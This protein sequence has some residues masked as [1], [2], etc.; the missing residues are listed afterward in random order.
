MEKLPISAGSLVNPG[1][2]ASCIPFTNLPNGM[3]KMKSFLVLKKR[4]ALYLTLLALLAISGCNESEIWCP[5]ELTAC[6]GTCYSLKT[7]NTHCGECGNACTGGKICSGGKCLVNCP[8]GQQLCTAGTQEYCAEVDKDINN[9]GSCGQK[10]ATGEVCNTG[11]CG[12][13][14]P[15]GL[16]KCGGGDAG[17]IICTNFKT[18]NKNCGSCGVTC[19]AGETCIQ[20]KCNLTC[21]VGLTLCD[22]VCVDLKS[23]ITNCGTC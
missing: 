1:L 22:G 9:C 18:D 16:S 7:D 11:T 2:R 23:D 17:V 15:P 6:D 8:P 10:C 20:G 4:P 12:L 19:K 14:C 13:S 3:V 21:Q 5:G